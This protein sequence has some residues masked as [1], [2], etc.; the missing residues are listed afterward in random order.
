M[1]WEKLKN[2]DVSESSAADG[3]EETLAWGRQERC[4]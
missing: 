3:V 1:E 4:Y 2:I